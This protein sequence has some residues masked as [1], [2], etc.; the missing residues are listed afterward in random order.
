MP[1]TA[2]VMNKPYVLTETRKLTPTITAYTFKAHDGTSIDFTPGM[3][4][5]LTY[6]DS[7]IN[8]SRAFSIANAPP[9]DSLEFV[10]ALVHGAF[11]SKLENAKVGDTYYISAPYGQFKFE[12]SA[13]EKILFFAGGTGIAPFLSMLRSIR[14]KKINMDCRMMYSVKYPDE[15]AENEEL[16]QMEIDMNLKTF[17]TVTR[18]KPEDNWKGDTGH[19]D[20]AMI[21]KDVPDFKD[22]VSYICGPPAFVKA[23]KDDLVSLGVPEKNIKAEMWG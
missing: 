21:Q 2:T 22:R 9:S 12:S 3:F 13:D 5:M 15:I 19:V 4:A 17:I 20:A 18:P 8:I 11:T 1:T 16:N 7:N 10:I 6:K 14:A 23:V